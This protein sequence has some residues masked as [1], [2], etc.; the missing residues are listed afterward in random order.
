MKESK[1][2]HFLLGRLLN[3]MHLCAMYSNLASDSL[4]CFD[5]KNYSK[6]ILGAVKQFL[7][8]PAW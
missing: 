6:V 1:K 8:A 7:G 4:P 2:L 3:F 5:L